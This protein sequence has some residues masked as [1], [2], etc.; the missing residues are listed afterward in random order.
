M[1]AIITM[2]AIIKSIH[3]QNVP[4]STRSS[5]TSSMLPLSVVTGFVESV[6]VGVAVVPPDVVD[7][8]V[9]EDSV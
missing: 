7:V 2:I 5:I 8:S 1:I 9:V 3:H 4:S 6:V